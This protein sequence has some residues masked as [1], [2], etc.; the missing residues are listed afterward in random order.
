MCVFQ[1]PTSLHCLRGRGRGRDSPPPPRH[2]VSL[3]RLSSD[4]RLIVHLKTSAAS[5]SRSSSSC[6]SA[7][8]PPHHNSPSRTGRTRRRPRQ[9]PTKSDKFGSALQTPF[10]PKTSRLSCFACSFRPGDLLAGGARGG[11]GHLFPEKN[12]DLQHLSKLICRFNE[13]FDGWMLRAGERAAASG[14]W[15]RERCPC[16]E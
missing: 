7:A 2:C 1:L 10:P 5:A 16:Q 12:R 8:P 6:P 9:P 14:A 4:T 11:G 15:R 3:Q 13:C